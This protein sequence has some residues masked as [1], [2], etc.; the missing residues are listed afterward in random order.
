MKPRT[1]MT[2]RKP[3]GATHL[4]SNAAARQPEEATRA[5]S[6]D[7]LPGADL[8]DA[9]PD[10][11]MAEE[12]WV[13]L[14]FPGPA[15]RPLTSEDA[16]RQDLSEPEG[17]AELKSSAWKKTGEPAGFVPLAPTPRKEP[18]PTPFFPPAD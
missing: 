4:R 11:S 14:D 18:A 2:T 16:D 1:A 12:A 10:G 6:D 7:L 9:A 17:R 3:R 8:L 5:R 13:G 15:P